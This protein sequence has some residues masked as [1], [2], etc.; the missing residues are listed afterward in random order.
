MSSRRSSPFELNAFVGVDGD[1]PVS[2]QLMSR[3]QGKVARGREVLGPLKAAQDVLR[4]GNA[5]GHLQRL[6]ANARVD[7]QT[8]IHPFPHAAQRVGDDVSAVVAL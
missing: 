2:A 7:D 3:V 5:L 6:V 8:H 1:R 4:S